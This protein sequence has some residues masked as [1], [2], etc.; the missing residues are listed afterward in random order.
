MPYGNL[1]RVITGGALLVLIGTAPGFAAE[2]DPTVRIT[3][4][5]VAAGVGISWG[6]PEKQMHFTI[7]GED[8]E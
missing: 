4:K 2:P 7:V 1:F 3:G 5:S 8:D 6:H